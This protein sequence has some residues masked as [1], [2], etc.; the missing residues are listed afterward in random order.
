NANQWKVAFSGD[1]LFVAK[2]ANGTRQP[3]TAP[4][5]LA[6]EPVTNRLFVFVG[7]G[8]YI[9]DSDIT[10]TSTQT[11]YALIDTGAAISG[12]SDL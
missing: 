2:D 5:A 4:V 6:R 10:S 1:P 3:I 12:R 11:L 9:Y 8:R 7:T